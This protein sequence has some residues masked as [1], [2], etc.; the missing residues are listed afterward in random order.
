MKKVWYSRRAL[1]VMKRI[2]Q[3]GSL[4]NDGAIGREEV[5]RPSI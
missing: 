2:S 1:G 4:D 5:E 3:C